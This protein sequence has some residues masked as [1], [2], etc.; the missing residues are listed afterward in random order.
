[1]ILTVYEYLL[2]N[3]PAF[4]LVSI[5]TFVIHMSIYFGIYSVYFFL[6]QMP[7]MKKYKIQKDK[8]PTPQMRYNAFIKILMGD[9]W[10]QLPMMLFTQPILSWLGTRMDKPFPAFWTESLPQAI[11]F[12]IVEDAWFYWIHRLLHYG[13]FYRYIHKIHHEHTYPFGVVAEYAHPFEVFLLGFGTFLGPIIFHPHLVTLW[14]WLLVRIWQEID[15]HCGYDF[16]W[17]GN[18]WIPFFGGAEF[19]DFHHMN[20]VGNYA[21]TFRW[22][23]YVFGTDNKYYQFKAKLAEEKKQ[24]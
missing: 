7:S 24:S 10:P 6:E 15:C 1:M 19:H 23:D 17:S 20:F 14:F 2:D 5:G 11:C 3:V 8:E 18:H 22:W 21:S 4:W 16:P 9:L 13:V 12:C